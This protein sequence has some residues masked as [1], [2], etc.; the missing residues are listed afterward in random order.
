VTIP[1]AVDPFFNLKCSEMEQLGSDAS[2]PEDLCTLLALVLHGVCGCTDPT[3]A[4]SP[5]PSSGGNEP[6]SSCSAC[7]E[8][9]EMTVPSGTIP[10]PAGTEGAGGL[11]GPIPCNFSDVSALLG[12][13]LAGPLCSSFQNLAFEPCGCVPI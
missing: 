1:E 10:F 11:V 2:I 3:P 6:D 4:P 5:S 12:I 13:I 7:A 9:F 8:G